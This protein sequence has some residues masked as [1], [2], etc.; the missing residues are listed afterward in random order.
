M[1]YILDTDTA[2][3]FFRGVSAVTQRMLNAD[4]RDLATTTVSLAELYFGAFNSQRVDRNLRVIDDFRNRV[5]VFSFDSAAA[6]VFGQTKASWRRTRVVLGDTDLMIA[7]IAIS[8][9]S[10]LV[11]HNLR[12]FR[13]VKDLNWED[14]SEP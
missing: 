11:T 10:T 12:H 4:A 2:I 6:V 7:S 8:T 13:P 1:T 5:K 14:W 9:G 3:V